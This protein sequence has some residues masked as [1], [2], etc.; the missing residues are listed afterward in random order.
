KELEVQNVPNPMSGERMKG[1]YYILS[2]AVSGDR[3]FTGFQDR[4]YEIRLYNPDGRLTRLIRKDYKHVPVPEE[5]K[6]AFMSQFENPMFDSIRDKIYF[7][8]AMPP[9]IGFV[10]DEEG[11]L[12][13]LTYETGER[14]GENMVDV[15]NRDGVFVGRRSL[16]LYY[17][18][19][20]PKARV[21]NGRLYSVEEKESGYKRLVI[22]RIRLSIPHF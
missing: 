8:A 12:Y 16:R 2:W 20:G 10:A 5:H 15:F 1:F 9:F 4:D 18:E 14:P 19:F 6:Q 17:D 7:P 21:K 22:S 11:C 13:V 3:I